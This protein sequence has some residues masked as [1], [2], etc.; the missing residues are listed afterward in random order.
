MFDGQTNQSYKRRYVCG[1]VIAVFLTKLAKHLA[2]IACLMIV[3]NSMAKFASTPLAIFLT[4]TA[5]A[6]LNCAGCF[7]Q[8]RISRPSRPPRSQP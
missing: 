7:L 2:L 6:L 3:A 1:H 4:V 8:Q 5:A